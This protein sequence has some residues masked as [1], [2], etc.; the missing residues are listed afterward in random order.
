[1][2]ILFVRMLEGQFGHVLSFVDEAIAFPIVLGA[3]AIFISVYKPVCLYANSK[4]EC[5]Y[6]FKTLYENI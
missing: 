2:W 6:F 4:Y 3:I 1:M 5:V